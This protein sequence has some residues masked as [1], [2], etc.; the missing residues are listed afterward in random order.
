MTFAQIKQRGPRGQ[1]TAQR[2]AVLQVMAR[3]GRFRTAQ[4][5]YSD[6]R[7]DGTNVGLTTVY[8]HLQRLADEGALHSLQLADRQTAYRLCSDAPHHH[9][10]CTQCGSAF[11]ITGGTVDEWASHEAADRGFADV[12]PAIDVFGTCPT[13]AALLG[14]ARSGGKGGAR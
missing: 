5:V 11:E 10:V 4:E 9:L 7:E 13:C 8:R 3:S 2:R 6:L 14:G 1:G 12:R